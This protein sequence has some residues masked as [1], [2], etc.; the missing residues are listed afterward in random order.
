MVWSTQLNKKIKDLLQSHI[1]VAFKLS[2][3]YLVQSSDIHEVTVQQDDDTRGGV[4]PLKSFFRILIFPNGS[5]E[6]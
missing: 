5:R 4:K 2:S 1:L 3:L 6:S